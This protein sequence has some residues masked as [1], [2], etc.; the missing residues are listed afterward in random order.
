MQSGSYRPLGPLRG[1]DIGTPQI[2]RV[3][4]IDN[5]TVRGGEWKRLLDDFSNDPFGWSPDTTRYIVAA[6]LMAGQQQPQ[7]LF[8]D[9]FAAAFQQQQQQQ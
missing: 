4:Q 3:M 8:G 5:E 7:S 9:P 2:R 1:A 6:M